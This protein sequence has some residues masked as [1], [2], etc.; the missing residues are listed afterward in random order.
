M[1]PNE[2]ENVVVVNPL[3]AYYQY[4]G[5]DPAVVKDPVDT[6]APYVANPFYTIFVV[7][8]GPKKAG[9]Y[10]Y[11]VLAIEY[12]PWLGA[13]APSDPKYTFPNNGTMSFEVYARDVDEYYAEYA[14][15]VN[16]FVAE[17]SGTNLEVAYTLQLHNLNQTD[18]IYPYEPAY[19]TAHH[20]KK[21]SSSVRSRGS[22]SSPS[23]KG[24]RM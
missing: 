6:N 7:K 18:C 4:V 5:S 8:V 24:A 22:R 11:Y 16:A 13:V 17:K 15:E 3:K 21:K 12:A 23:A 2:N 14:A 10:A 19:T 1:R 9:T 20:G